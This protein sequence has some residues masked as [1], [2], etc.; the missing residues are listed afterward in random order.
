MFAVFGAVFW[1]K[2][3]RDE[4]HPAEGQGADDSTA[5]ST[6]DDGTVPGAAGS[7]AERQLARTG[8]RTAGGGASAGD[9]DLSEDEATELAEYNA[10][11]AELSNAAPRPRGPR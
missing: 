11:L 4:L 6:A 1:V 9:D 8:G 10:Y 3:V 7:L 5:Y 2:T